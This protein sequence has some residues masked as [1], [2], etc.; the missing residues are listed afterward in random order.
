MGESANRRTRTTSVK[1]DEKKQNE[2]LNGRISETAT[3]AIRHF[4]DLDVYQNAFETRIQVYEL[5]RKFP[6]S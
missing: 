5:T 2:K 6:D 3:K 4:R 1:P